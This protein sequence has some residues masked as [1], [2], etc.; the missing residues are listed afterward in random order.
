MQGVDTQCDLCDANDPQRAHPPQYMYDNGNT[1]ALTW[2]Q[3][4]SWYDYPTPL[5][6][7]ITLSLGHSYRISD[8][9]TF[10]FEYGR[11]Q[12]MILEKSSDHGENWEVYQYYAA[13]EMGCTERDADKEGCNGQ[14]VSGCQYVFG[15]PVTS[16]EN[17]ATPTQVICTDQ[18][19]STIRVSDVDVT[20]LINSRI[21]LLTNSFNPAD[22]VAAYEANAAFQAF[23]DITDL[24]LRLLYP[25]TDGLEFSAQKSLFGLGKYYYAITDIQSVL[26]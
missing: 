7:N 24:R 5:E 1:G 11:P 9:L 22:I 23:L 6:I 18:Y 25:P 15:M 4:S 17:L 13:A 21:M 2:W 8:D 16:D 14:V 26:T 10:L 20:F 3:S 19:S 12:L